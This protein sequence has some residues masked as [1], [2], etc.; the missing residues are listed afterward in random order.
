[1]DRAAV[2]NSLKSG[3]YPNVIRPTLKSL[4][5]QRAQHHRNTTFPA[6]KTVKRASVEAPSDQRVREEKY[7]G[8][9]EASQ[10]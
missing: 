2:N 10:V 3:S 1:M 6:G 4:R 5:F 9:G 7:G 8:C